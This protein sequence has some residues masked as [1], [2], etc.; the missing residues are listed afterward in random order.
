MA[1][2]AADHRAVEAVMAA[3]VMIGEAMIV[4]ILLEGAT[5][6]AIEVDPGDMLRTN[7][8]LIRLVCLSKNESQVTVHSSRLITS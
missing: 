7:M 6:G 1:V 5:V 8:L 2:E 3:E 4:V